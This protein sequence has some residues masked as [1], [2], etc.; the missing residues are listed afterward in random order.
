[1][2][3]ISSVGRFLNAANNKADQLTAGAKAVLCLPSLLTNIP[4]AIK[5]TIGSVLSGLGTTLENIGS[6]I[7]DIVLN[8]VNGA[9]STITGS[10]VNTID[11][12]TSTLAQLGSVIEQVQ[13][14]KDGILDRVNDVKEFTS[15]KQNCDFAAAELLNCIVSQTLASV[16]PTIAVDVAKG[17]K[18]VA[19]VANDVSRAISSPGGAISRT[20]NKA[21]NEIDRATRVIEK[22]N[23]F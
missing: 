17:L 22:S 18:P 13:E 12:A 7:S 1:M 14:F 8:T 5:A 19:D 11:L 23:I 6:T 20:V 16:T 15:D 2:P 9:V 4:G 21:A 3:L 10:I